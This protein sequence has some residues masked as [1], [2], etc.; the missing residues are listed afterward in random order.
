MAKRVKKLSAKMKKLVW[1]GGEGKPDEYDDPRYD[2]G[3]IKPV[4]EVED[5]TEFWPR[6]RPYKDREP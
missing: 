1:S 4:I 3:R 5:G 2:L 6:Y